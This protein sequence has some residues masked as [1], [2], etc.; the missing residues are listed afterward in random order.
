MLLT[1]T[2]THRPATDLGYVL[3]KHP[4]NLHVV[5]L[6]FGRATIFYPE[7]GEERCTAALTVEVDP[8]EL[9]RGKG[10]GAGL[11][12]QYVNDRPYAASSLL[13]VAL[14]RALGT[15]MSGRSKLRQ[16]LADTAL[17]L[18]ATVTPLPARGGGAGLI[19]RLFEPLGYAVEARAIAMD[20]A[21]PEWGD[22][23]YVELRLTG[24]A[25]VADLLNHLFVLI[26]V[27]DKA[28]H[29]YIGE[30]EV[31][32]LLRKGEGWLDAHPERELIVRRYLKG[33]K[34]LVRIAQRGLDEAPEVE[35]AEASFARDAEE[36]ALEKPQRLNDVRLE[37][38]AAVLKELGAASVLD[39]GCGE[40]KLLRHLLQKRG[41]TRIV[42]MEVAPRVLAVAA[43]RL[44]L[45][46]MPD[47]QRK[48]IELIQGSLVYRD[49]RLKGFDAAAV[50]E[51][52]EHMDADRLPSFEQALFG[53]A[54]PGAV[55]ITTPNADYNA[56]FPSLPA[57]RMRHPDHR[58]EWS[59]SEFE[60]WAR[61]VAAAH[62]YEVRFEAIGPGDAALG[63]PTQMGVFT[64]A[65]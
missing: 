22:S 27:L 2:T 45:E 64:R 56:L 47:L 18:E 23:P 54:R 40:G 50:V 63:G 10:G 37:R 31:A 48:R 4:D 20:P 14:G 52:I 19:A 39:L 3:M 55:V 34:S 13:S 7:A 42:G 51:V 6:P 61:S 9:V 5:E 57:G 41:F 38:V 53:H 44:R 21:H 12:D 24:R 16:E 35:E 29:Y 43:E 28:K 59:R 25:R 49:D 46:S 26:P 30:D 17:P 58:F 33:F 60:H 11:Q 62:R 8:V 32:K 1:L 36:E 65:D 15:A